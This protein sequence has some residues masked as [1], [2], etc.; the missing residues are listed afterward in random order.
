[1]S[2]LSTNAR[3]L[4]RLREIVK[5]NGCLPI[6]KT[7]WWEGVKSGKFPRPIKLGPKISAWK[8][9]DIEHLINNGID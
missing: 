4:L 2:D 6:G 5:P 9:G 8:A 7:A 1:M 3:P